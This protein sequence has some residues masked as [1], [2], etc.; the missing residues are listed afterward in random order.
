M[1]TPLLTLLLA[2]V[3][4][5]LAWAGAPT[6][7]RFQDPSKPGI[8]RISVSAGKLSIHPS[9][10]AGLV[11]VNSGSAQPKTSPRAREDGL[12]V[13]GDTDAAYSLTAE[14][15][16]ADLSYGQDTFDKTCNFDVSVP[17][18]T[19]LQIQNTWGGEIVIQSIT[20]DISLQGM[21]CG[22]SLE[23]VSGGANIE[24]MNGKVSASYTSLP[25][26]KSI[27]IS[28][29][30]GSVSMRVPETAKANV[31]FR[32]HNGAILTDFSEDILKTKS[33]DLGGNNWGAMAG[34]QAAMAITMARRY[35]IEIA[36]EARQF[37]EEMKDGLKHSSSIEATPKAS[38]APALEQ[39]Q[40]APIQA[41]EAP[42]SPKPP[43]APRQRVAINIP[44]LS[45]GKVVSGTLNEGG[46]SIQITLLN[47]DVTFR[48]LPKE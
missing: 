34:K 24:V 47:G 14:G 45:G 43:K 2:I 5:P 12:R 33:E 46:T 4:P 10:E 15:N 13:L 23:K 3:V 11:T 16:T 40:S 1:R 37:S 27:S 18:N 22:V 35:G 36:N 41:P 31:R 17:A 9:T 19:Q 8:L 21:N 6:Q 39:S 42:A 20:G 44:A 28:A 30:N 32:T 29:M 48:R 7:V 26:D 25:A 38:E